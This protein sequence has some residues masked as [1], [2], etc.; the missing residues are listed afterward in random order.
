MTLSRW[1]LLRMRNVSN[2]SCIEN[3]NTY[4]MFSDFFPENRAVYEIM[5]KM[6]WSQMDRNDV[7]IWRVRVAC[8]IS[9]ATR[10]HTPTHPA[11]IVTRTGLNVTL[12]VYCVSCYILKVVPLP[13]RCDACLSQQR[14][15][16]DPRPVLVRFIVDKL[17]MGLVVVR[18]L[19][20]AP[21]SFVPSVLQTR[22][23]DRMPCSL[24]QAAS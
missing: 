19:R 17:A 24:Y 13:R 4:F 18:V 1:F 14:T 9:T 3:Q 6:W 20:F 12:Y 21:V 16:F 2:E 10:T 22:L 8:G 23:V 15:G 7:T 5:R 11:T